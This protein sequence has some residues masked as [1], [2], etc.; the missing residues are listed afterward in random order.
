[1]E[2]KSVSESGAGEGKTL[3][4]S[5]AKF[6]VTPTTVFL[7]IQALRRAPNACVHH[8]FSVSEPAKKEGRQK[9]GS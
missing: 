3:L 7:S 5:I 8:S 1:M 4:L 9:I 2:V 6:L